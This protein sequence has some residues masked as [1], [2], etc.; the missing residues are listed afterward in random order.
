M[1]RLLLLLLGLACAGTN[2]YFLRDPDPT[3]LFQY[4]PLLTAVTLNILF[5]L[6]IQE[7]SQ[8]KLTKSKALR[9]TAVNHHTYYGTL[10]LT[11]VY[12]FI[13]IAYYSK[14]LHHKPHFATTHGQCGLCALVLAVVHLICGFLVH[15][16]L[17]PGNIK[18]TIRYAHSINS[19]L[20][21]LFMMVTLLYGLE[22]GYALRHVASSYLRYSLG[23]TPIVMMLLAVSL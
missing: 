16:V 21:T 2:V 18:S 23:S 22:T 19:Y 10:G 5:P 6:A 7:A 8:F 20:L 3:A 4:H 17:P 13:G 9:D 11:L 14:E 1:N 15:Y 12:V